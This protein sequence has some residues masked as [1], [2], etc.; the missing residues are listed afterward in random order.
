MKRKIVLLSLILFVS[1]AS[2]SFGLGI[3]VAGGIP[4]GEGLP[5]TNV[6]LSVKLPDIPIVFGAGFRID[7]FALGITADWWL[8]QEP[9]VD[10]LNVYLGPGIY[11]GYIEN[12][13]IDLGGRLPI[14]LNIYP[15]SWLELF[16]EVAPTLSINLQNGQFPQFGVQAS[17]GLRF[18]L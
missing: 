13:T 8:I 1:I 16:L 18:W 12:S 6:L 17:I 7:N 15:I 4:I 5:G 10:L 2:F 11:F 9:L 3:G 14:G